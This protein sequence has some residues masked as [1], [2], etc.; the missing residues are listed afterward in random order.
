MKIEEIIELHYITPI[1]NI[2]SILEKGILCHDKAQNI[3]HES[4]A[5]EEIQD[6]RARK[7][8]PGGKPLHHYA[9]L[10][11]NARNP[12]MYK[13]SNEHKNICIL[14][15]NP[16]ILKMAGAIVTDGNAASDYTA[17]YQPAAGIDKLDSKFIYTDSWNDI[18]PI[19]K[20]QKAHKICAEVL[21]PDKISA[22]YIKGAYV[23]IRE[24]VDLLKSMNFNL[25]I[26]IKSYIFFR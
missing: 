5:M 6:I 7:I 19:S 10:Y 16:D 11:F 20:W 21:V 4:V 9:N 26:E 3:A 13:R 15:I 1:K 24:N 25:P 14:K 18:N 22:E 12:M 17:F 2:P 8:V 23:S